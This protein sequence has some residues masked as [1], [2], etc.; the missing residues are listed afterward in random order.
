MQ[1]PTRVPAAVP[2]TL[3]RLVLERASWMQS[4]HFAQSAVGLAGCSY[5][6]AS[7]WLGFMQAADRKL[8]SFTFGQLADVLEAFAFVG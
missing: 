3:G 6:D 5:T 2:V 4:A 1:A 7:F 8:G